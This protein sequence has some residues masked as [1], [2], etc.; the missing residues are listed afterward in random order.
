MSVTGSRYVS[1]ALA[2]GIRIENTFVVP[3][4][5]EEAWK[6]LVDLPRVVPCM[7]GTELTEA[8]DARRF[9]ATARL[10]VGP[11]ELQFKGDGELYA[12]D[13]TAHTAKLRAKG[14]DAKGRGAFQTEMALALAPQGSETAVR[15]DT[16]L[17]LSGSVAQYGRGAGVVK[18]MA[19]QLSAQFARNL[20]GLMSTSSGAAASG[21]AAGE[22]ATPREPPRTAPISGLALFFAAIKAMLRRLFG[23]RS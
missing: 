8:L 17:T 5:V 20:A 4:P 22:E 23:G 15:V 13:A 14:T 11:V 19:Q 9:R 3:A 21:S 18:E 10:R 7:P 2:V 1:I 12:V 16:D 6:V